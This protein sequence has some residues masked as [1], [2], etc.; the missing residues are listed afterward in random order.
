MQ[1]ET[2][3]RGYFMHIACS[4]S[5]RWEITSVG[6]DEKHK[7]PCALLREFKSNIATR[8]NTVEAPQKMENEITMRSSNLMSWHRSKE[9]EIIVPKRYNWELMPLTLL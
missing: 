1:I 7:E 3:P 9:T 8:E 4:L 2:K 6:K 5:K